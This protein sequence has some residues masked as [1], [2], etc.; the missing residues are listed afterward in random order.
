MSDTYVLFVLDIHDNVFIV[1]DFSHVYI[2]LRSR[3]KTSSSCVSIYN[4]VENF[5]C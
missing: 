3:I 5:M 2:E 4:K 1:Y